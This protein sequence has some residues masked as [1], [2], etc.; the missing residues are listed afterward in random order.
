MNAGDLNRWRGPMPVAGMGDRPDF[1][2]GSDFVADEI[3]EIRAAGRE[4]GQT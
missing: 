1:D 2:D 3:E 4:N